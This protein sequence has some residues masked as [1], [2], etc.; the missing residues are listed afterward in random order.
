MQIFMSFIYRCKY[1]KKKKPKKIKT[2]KSKHKA[3]IQVAQG[4][5][6]PKKTPAGRRSL[7]QRPPSPVP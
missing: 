2:E 7:S 5:V 1:P 4:H 6:E 3:L